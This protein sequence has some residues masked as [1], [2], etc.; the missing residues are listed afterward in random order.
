MDDI[1]G[2]LDDVSLQV[3][4]LNRERDSSAST[5]NPVASLSALTG[6]NV[7]VHFPMGSSAL[8]ANAQGLL[9]EVAASMRQVPQG[10]LLV[11]GYADPSG[12][13]A[14]NLALSEQRAKAVRNYL[15][16]RGVGGDRILLNYFGASQS[17]GAGAAERRVE[18]EWIR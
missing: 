9:N 6:K 8:D 2:R 14:L 5:E 7:R 3:D 10:R 16:Q 4:E 15:L 17:T 12:S 1:E 13:P 18:L 11:T